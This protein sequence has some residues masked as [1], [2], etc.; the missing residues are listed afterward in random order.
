MKSPIP[1]PTGTLIAYGNA[2]LYMLKA[3]QGWHME[4]RFLVQCSG[5]GVIMTGTL[6]VETRKIVSPDKISC[7][8]IRIQSYSLLNGGRAMLLPANLE[9]HGT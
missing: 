2:E 8:K 4:S 6:Q 7:P 9:A 1:K 5:F 3:E